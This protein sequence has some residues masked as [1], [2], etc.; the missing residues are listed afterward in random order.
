MCSSIYNSFKKIHAT[1]KEMP[2]DCDFL[3]YI[4]VLPVVGHVAQI[5]KRSIMSN[6]LS[7][8]EEEY[9][10]LKGTSSYSGAREFI[11]KKAENLA[12]FAVNSFD[13][14]RYTDVAC[15]IIGIALVVLV[16]GSTIAMCFFCFGTVS[17]MGRKMLALWDSNKLMQ[18]NSESVDEFQSFLHSL[19]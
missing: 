17:L 11:A 8:K 16:P 6:E 15:I 9:A 5:W 19:K 12:N 3:K 14:G 4:M 10:H 2:F 1:V 13:Y 7:A 18:L